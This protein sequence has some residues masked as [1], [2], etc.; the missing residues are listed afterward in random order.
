MS[1]LCINPDEDG[2][3]CLQGSQQLTL[4]AASESRGVVGRPPLEGED[5]KNVLATGRK[6]AEAVAP[7]WDGMVCE[8]KG[9]A[10]AGGGVLP[11]VGC[12]GYPAHHRHHGPD[13]SVLNNTV[14]L[15]LH[16][17]CDF[18]HVRWHTANDIFYGPNGEA[19]RPPAGL[20]WVPDV[21]YAPHDRDTQ[22]TPAE[23]EASDLAWKSRELT[24]KKLQ[25]GS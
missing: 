16:R 3:P 8:W 13:K 9:L 18:C 20:P 25:K 6:R 22:A 23:V 4:V 21:E 1:I 2:Q 17:V 12:P 15:N 11:I 10:A 14:G 7:I 24:A 19:D 5:M